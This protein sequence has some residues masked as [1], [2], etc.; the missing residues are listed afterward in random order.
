VQAAISKAR[1]AISTERATALDLQD[2]VGRALERSDAMRAEIAGLRTSLERDLLMRESVPLWTALSEARAQGSLA[3]PI[4]QAFADQMGELSAGWPPAPGTW[5][6][7]LAITAASLWGVFAIRR[8]ALRLADEDPSFATTASLFDRPYSVALIVA[9]LISRA[10]WQD[11]PALG[12]EGLRTL[13]LFPALRLLEQVVGPAARRPVVALAG[14]YIIDRART[15]I[16]SAPVVER[17]VFGV[18]MAAACAMIAWLLRPS[19]LSELPAGTSGL[20]LVGRGLQ[21]ALALCSIALVANLVGYVRLG[22]VVGDGAIRSLFVAVGFFATY[23]VA[24]GI[25]AALRRA[26]P[27]RLIRALRPRPL[28]ARQRARSILAFAAFVA[29]ALTTL[30]LFTVRDDVVKWVRGV[31]EARLEVGELS[32]SLGGVVAFGLTLW[33]AFWFA[34]AIR[35]LLEEDV[36]SRMRL[37]RG[38]PNAVAATV[39]YVAVLLGFFLALAVIGI[40]LTQFTILAGAVG[41]GVGF[42][43]QNVVNG[44]VSGLILLYER[45]VQVGDVVQIA[46]FNGTVRRIGIRSSTV[47]TFDGGEVIVPNSNL[48]SERFVN[49]TLSDRLRR[50]DIDLGVDYASEPRKVLQLLT[51]VAT[52]HSAVL[53]NPAPLALFRGFGAN[54]LDFQL[55]AWTENLDDAAIVRSD[56]CV[57]IAAALSAAE[58]QIRLPVYDVRLKQVQP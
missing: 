49:W 41:V 11:I 35:Y 12:E 3:A 47:R 38:V 57:A 15:V 58:I 9:V 27:L 4:A 55:R 13:L 53:D 56:L 34:R 32:L 51:D 1:K 54:S 22:F 33:A 36:F 31:L 10:F 45:P 48:I 37:P 43:M 8:R 16:E 5:L 21:I 40:N 6:T 52:A 42:G 17:L 28:S 14:F 39:Q 7:L 2:R 44:F 20:R 26:W 50:I 30:E 24:N 46:D 18:E 25:V 29:W 23:R 19:R